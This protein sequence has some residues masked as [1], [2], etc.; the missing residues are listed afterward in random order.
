MQDTS[1]RVSLITLEY[2][3]SNGTREADRE[4]EARPTDIGTSYMSDDL[5]PPV[6]VD[7]FDENCPGPARFSRVVTEKKGRRLL[8]GYCPTCKLDQIVVYEQRNAR[9]LYR[10]KEVAKEFPVDGEMFEWTEWYD[11]NNERVGYLMDGAFRMDLGPIHIANEAETE[12]W[13]RVDPEGYY[14]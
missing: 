5:R 12:F 10:A 11:R 2:T 3:S 14:Q 1:T 4:H 9:V 8:E 7:C 13:K 6:K